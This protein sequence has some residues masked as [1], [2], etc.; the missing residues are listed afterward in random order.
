MSCLKCVYREKGLGFYPAVEVEFCPFGEEV[1][2][3]FRLF[4]FR[5]VINCNVLIFKLNK[6]PFR[7]C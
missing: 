1:S 2:T 5:C 6:L 3:N 7:S 4:T